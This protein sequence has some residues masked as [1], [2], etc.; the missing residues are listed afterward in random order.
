MPL[1]TTRVVHPDRAAELAASIGQT[2]PESATILRSTT[3]KTAGGDS[4]SWDPIGTGRPCRIRSLGKRVLEQAIGERTSEIAHW[5]ISFAADEDVKAF[6]R[7]AIGARTFA[8]TDGGVESYP[9]EVRCVCIEV[10]S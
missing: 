6:D 7:I 10:A 4:S 8:V 5:A 1:P 3:T 9:V 2:W